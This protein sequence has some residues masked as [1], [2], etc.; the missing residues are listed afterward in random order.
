[1][2]AVINLDPEAAGTIC[3]DPNMAHADKKRKNLL[4]DGDKVLEDKLETILSWPTYSYFSM[5]GNMN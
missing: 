2:D 4:V 5:S 1:M 3:F